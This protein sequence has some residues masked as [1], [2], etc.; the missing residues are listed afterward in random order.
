MS[1][2]RQ[3]TRSTNV[4]GNET[5]E[6]RESTRSRDVHIQ[7]RGVQ[8]FK[9]QRPG[10]RAHQRG[11]SGIAFTP[12]CTILNLR[13]CRRGSAEVPLRGEP[14]G[15]VAP[16]QNTSADDAARGHAIESRFSGADCSVHNSCSPDKAHIL[17]SLVLTRTTPTTH[18]Q[19]RG[20]AGPLI[21]W[22]ADQK[23]KTVRD[24]AVS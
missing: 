4:L 10:R 5:A 24:S 11:C 1:S 21:C 8:E 9:L 2:C 18:H 16:V 19:G 15:K 22:R 7:R 23:Y 13:S 12:L 6:E 14:S 17:V 20:A 3:M